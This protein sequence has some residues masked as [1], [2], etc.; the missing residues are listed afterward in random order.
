MPSRLSASGALGGA[1]GTI[2]AEGMG[3][4]V[5]MGT[6]KLISASVILLLLLWR[7]GV[8]DYEKPR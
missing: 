7:C 1:R 3:T 8:V 4:P 5:A 6:L 2:G